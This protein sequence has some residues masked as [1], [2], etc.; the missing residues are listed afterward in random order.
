MRSIL[1]LTIA[2]VAILWLP[3]SA[4]I[5]NV[6]A[7]QSTIQAGIN[8]SISGDTV[9][10]AL[11]IYV[12][13]INFSGKNIIVGSWFLDAG[14]TSYISSTIIDGNQSGIVVSLTNEEDGTAVITGFTIQNG[15]SEFM[16]RSHWP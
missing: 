4:T 16:V 9:R 15:A 6:S 5:I 1:I 10:V 3:V 2:A 12:E 7:D 11:G 14:D 8:S 13:N